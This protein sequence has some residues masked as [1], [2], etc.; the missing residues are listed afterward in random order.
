MDIRD[1]GCE[2]AVWVDNETRRMC[3]DAFSFSG[4][5]ERHKKTS[6]GSGSVRRCKHRPKPVAAGY[7]ASWLSTPGLAISC[8]GWATCGPVPYPG[9]FLNPLSLG[10]R[11]T[12]AHTASCLKSLV[13]L[14]LQ[15]I[16]TH[17]QDLKLSQMRRYILWP[18]GLFRSEPKFRSNTLHPS[19]GQARI[20]MR[21]QCL[22][23]FSKTDRLKEF[24]TFTGF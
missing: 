18:F 2:D 9:H 4:R 10:Q 21:A 13:I 5:I 15:Q 20:Y 14:T 3:N 12:R 22:T 23:A 8:S 19:S 16:W 11:R 24:Q 17:L 6:W 7:T 1:L